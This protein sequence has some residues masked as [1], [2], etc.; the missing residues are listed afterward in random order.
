MLISTTSEHENALPIALVHHH[1]VHYQ[2]VQEIQ[3]GREE[4]IQIRP[5]A[6]SGISAPKALED[7]SKM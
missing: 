7:D 2:A 5:Y 4:G 6:F 1:E 3:A